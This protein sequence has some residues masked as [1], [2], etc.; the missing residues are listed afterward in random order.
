[1]Y[2]Y[3]KNLL[4]DSDEVFI[5]LRGNEVFELVLNRSFKMFS[6]TVA[7]LKYLPILYNGKL[8]SAPSTS[9]LSCQDVSVVT[10]ETTL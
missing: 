7:H 9:A 1:M 4:K 2:G 3:V 8:T 6:D 10:G 5:P